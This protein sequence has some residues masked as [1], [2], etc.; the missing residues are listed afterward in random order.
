VGVDFVIRAAERSRHKPPSNGEAL[1]KRNILITTLALFLVPAL[2]AWAAEETQTPEELVDYVVESCEAEIE[3]YCSQVTP[4][5][6][7][8][9][10]CFYAHQDKLSGRCE[11]ALY[12]ASAVLESF[13]A[14][15]TY[16]AQECRDDLEKFCGD[17]KMG[18]GRVGMC[19]LDN[20]SKLSEGCSKA[21]D[22][23]GL[24]VVEE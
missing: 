17:V 11:Y 14:A 20:K 1:M 22:D 12:N 24:E 21:I 16:M 6:G 15:T 2:G 19:L 9:L 4:G 13:A 3:T 18:E 8:L 5:D 23:V 10:A 7:R